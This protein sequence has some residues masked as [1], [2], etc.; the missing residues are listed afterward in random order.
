M[1]PRIQQAQL[2]EEREYEQ[3]MQRLGEAEQE[4]LS[5]NFY[6]SEDYLGY[7]DGRP[8]LGWGW[9]GLTMGWRDY[10]VWYIIG[11]ALLIVLLIAGQALK[12]SFRRRTIGTVASQHE[13]V[14]IKGN[15]RRRDSNPGYG[16]TV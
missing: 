10:M 6:M 16:V 4:R 1:L 15:R 11:A 5:D 8:G 13:P 9:G 2:D 14:T 12:G 7:D 3:T